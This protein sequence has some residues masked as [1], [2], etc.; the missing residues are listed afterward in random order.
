MNELRYQRR[1]QGKLKAVLL[2]WA[3]T[4]LDHGC[5]APAVGYV[6]YP[7]KVSNADCFRIGHIGRLFVADMRALLAAVRQTMTEM[8]CPTPLLHNSG[9]QHTL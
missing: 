9:A 4:T 3:G 7:G 5:Y 6:I 8:G 2:D 1:Y